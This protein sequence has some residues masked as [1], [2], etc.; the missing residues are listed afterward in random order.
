MSILNELDAKTQS[1]ITPDGMRVLIIENNT[2]LFYCKWIIMGTGKDYEEKPELY[3]NFHLLE[4]MVSRYTTNGHPDSMKTSK[5]IIEKGIF[6]NAETHSKFTCYYFQGLAKY[7][8]YMIELMLTTIN[9]FKFDSDFFPQEKEAVIQ[10]LE[11]Y[12]DE[13]LHL[14]YE[15]QTHVLF[16]GCGRDRTVKQELDV[17]RKINE[18]Q[19]LK[20]FNQYYKK[21]NYVLM[22]GGPTKVITQ[23]LNKYIKLSTHTESKVNLKPLC[24]P[25]K[26]IK[27]DLYIV[28]IPNIQQADISMYFRIPFLAKD[29]DQYLYLE[30]TMYTLAGSFSSRLNNLLRTK[31]GL[32]YSIYYLID[33]D[34]INEKMSTAAIVTSCQKENYTKVIELLRESINKVNLNGITQ[35]EFEKS[36]LNYLKTKLY[37]LATDISPGRYVNDYLHSFV[38]E[39]RVR[40]NREIIMA[41]NHL[42]L[43]KVN[44]FS[45][46]Y[47]KDYII[48][49]GK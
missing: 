5:D 13:P 38:F 20:V 45:K 39:N 21:E 16:K 40:T 18:E 17:V 14:L 46:Y 22:I 2:G 11:A 42:T 30:A 24:S 4:H 28:D 7:M 44:E 19:L 9:N 34:E 35:D 49:V 32:I 31:Y 15:K 25:Q 41:I 1:Y 37:G 26:E 43:Q 27:Q 47:L 23:E 33:F 3:E 12:L 8:S 48:F 6:F 29:I 10:E 36:Y